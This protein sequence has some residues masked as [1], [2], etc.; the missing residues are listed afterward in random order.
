M[1]SGGLRASARTSQCW[2][3]TRGGS[4]CGQ[5]RP[6]SHAGSCGTQ[7]AD[8]ARRKPLG[9]DCCNCT[10]KV[11]YLPSELQQRGISYAESKTECQPTKHCKPYSSEIP[12]RPR[13]R[14]AHGLCPQTQPYGHRDS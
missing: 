1:T 6:S 10:E 11:H 5:A 3:A 13:D 14:K 2:P 12:D 8:A 4:A 7:V 9:C